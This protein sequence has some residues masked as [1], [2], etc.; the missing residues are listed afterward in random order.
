MFLNRNKNN[1]YSWY[2][3]IKSKD[4]GGN[5]TMAYLNFSF[6]KG[7]EPMP[8]EL[9]GEYGSY[10]GE[11]IFRDTT[12]AERK[13]FPIA[14]EYNGIK[15][16]ELKLLAKEGEYQDP[17]PTWQPKTESAST[18]RTEPKWDLRPKEIS[19]DDL[20]FDENEIRWG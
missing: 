3:T 17:H 8:N 2:A 12:G 15:S 18:I 9:T 1:G 10:E 6:K 7:F 20:P 5:E 16:V 19:E 14:K 11:L 4:I 13:V